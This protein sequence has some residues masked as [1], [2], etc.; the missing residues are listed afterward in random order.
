MSLALLETRK[1]ALR[2]LNGGNPARARRFL[3]KAI[4]QFPDDYVLLTNAAALAYNEGRDEDA[5]R[6]IHEAYKRPEAE[7]SPQF[8]YTKSMIDLKHGNWEIGWQEHESRFLVRQ[9]IERAPACT[10]WDGS[11]LGPDRKLV[12]WNEQG[13]GDQIQMIRFCKQAKEKSGAHVVAVVAPPLVKLFKGQADE[14]SARVDL[15]PGDLHAPL[16]SL[17]RILG[18]SVGNLDGTPYIKV[19]AREKKLPGQFMVGLC[20]MGNQATPELAERSMREEELLPI[21]ENCVWRSLQYGEYRFWPN[22]FSETAKA[23][24]ACD[25]VITIDTSI[26]HLAGAMGIPTWVML[27]YNACWRWLRNREDTPW[28]KNMVLYRQPKMGDWTSLVQKVAEDLKCRLS[29]K[30]G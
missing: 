21:R 15:D 4:E 11:Y 25:L 23:V 20:W 18:V 9:A 3:R 27:R 5:L 28:Y 19:R 1:T 16:F 30:V 7:N 2:H 24:A 22:D 10:L 13:L 8:W 6:I 17:P 14:I 29:E 12:L 26:A